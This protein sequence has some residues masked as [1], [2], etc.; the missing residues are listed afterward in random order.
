[1]IYDL[2]K[3]DGRNDI[4]VLLAP[5]LAP[6]LTLQCS[7]LVIHPFGVVFRLR[8]SSLPVFD[9]LQGGSRSFSLQFS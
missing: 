2:S 6:L 1:M 3:H 8:V 4:Y 9:L 7:Y 5:T